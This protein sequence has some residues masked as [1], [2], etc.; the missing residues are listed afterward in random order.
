MFALRRVHFLQ[1]TG[2]A[3]N[4]SAQENHLKGYGEK[5]LENSD[6]Q[7]SPKFVSKTKE[8]IFPGMGSRSKDEESPNHCEQNLAIRKEPFHHKR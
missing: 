1:L 4:F 7:N 3:S 8:T 5:G 2:S 6:S